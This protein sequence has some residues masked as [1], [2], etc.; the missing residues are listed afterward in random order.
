MAIIKFAYIKQSKG[1]K[2]GNLKKAIDYIQREDRTVKGEKLTSENSIPSGIY[3]D[4]INCSLKNAL[5]DMVKT[6]EFYGKDIK[7][8]LNTRMGYHFKISWKPGENITYEKAMQ[9]TKEFCE[10]YLNGFECV[11][12]V[13]T[14]TKHVHTHIVFN[15]VNM[16]SGYKYRYEDDDWAKI[17]QP[18]L[19]KICNKYGVHTLSEDTGISME[20]YDEEIKRRRKR[21][22]LSGHKSSNGS[23]YNEKDDIYDRKQFLKDVL[24]DVVLEASTKKEFYDLLKEKGF[25]IRIGQSKNYGEYF[26]MR[27]KG[28]RRPRRNY[29]LGGNYTVDSLIRRIEAKNKPLPVFPA[30]EE[31]IYVFKFMYWKT[32]RKDMTELQ[33]KYCYGLYEK[34]LYKRNQKY[35]Y[36]SIRKSLKEIQEIQERIDIINDNNISSV[37]DIL[38]Y[39]QGLEQRKADLDEEKKQLYFKRKPYEALILAV[40]DMELYEAGYE[41]FEKDGVEVYKK[42]HELYKKAFD[43]YEKYGMGLSDVKIF[44]KNFEEKLKELKQ[45]KRKINHKIKTASI[46]KK[47]YED[48]MAKQYEYEIP[49]VY[50]VHSRIEKTKK[51]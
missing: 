14:N 19:D 9:I 36:G 23:Y 47:S 15:S 41:A 5:S 2:Y 12:A 21:D 50:C 40:K 39:I 44:T 17:V 46:I 31:Y 27:C 29:A 51:K 35:D 45:E 25:E 3:V 4:S 22:R 6:K 33:K 20:D 32:A 10:K 1:S 43:V 18:L 16:E 49:K 13:H 30:K 11:Y 48:V 8:N 42:E 37:N 26:T 34:G 38:Q 24:D 7:K 28:M